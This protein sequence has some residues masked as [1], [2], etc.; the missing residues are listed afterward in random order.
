MGVPTSE[1]SYT[2]VMSRREDHEV[3]KRTCGDNG[4]KKRK[5][6]VTLVRANN[7]LPE[8]G[9][10]VTTEKYRSCLNVN[11]NFVFKTISNVSIVE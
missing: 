2:P 1:V 11:F 10:T 6:T 9:V 7:A 4:K 8:D 5:K 3:Y